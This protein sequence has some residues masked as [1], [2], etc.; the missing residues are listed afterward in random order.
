M[1]SEDGHEVRYRYNGDGLLYE[2]LENGVTTRYYYDEQGDLFREGIVQADGSLQLTARYIYGGQGAGPIARDD[3]QSDVVLYYV[4]NGHGDVT[5][6]V[7][8]VGN[9]VNQY[10]YD[11]WGN[12]LSTSELQE[13]PFRYSGEY[14]DESTGLQYLRAR[15]YDPSVGRFINEDTYE[16]Q[17]DNPLTLNLYTYVYNNPLLYTDP[18][19]HCGINSLR[20]ASDCVVDFIPFVGAGKSI[21]RGNNW[22]EFDNWRSINNY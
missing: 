13:T 6:V 10:T 11:I 21:Q 14:W 1:T 15:W 3:I 17:I 22:K 12:P 7:D 5:G 2:R 9:I 18:T 16:G 8:G 20:N 19:G 4:N